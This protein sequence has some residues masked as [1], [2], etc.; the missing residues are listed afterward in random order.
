MDNIAQLL[1]PDNLPLDIGEKGTVE[2]AHQ[3]IPDVY[4][5]L[6]L[7]SHPCV[8][9]DDAYLVLR[10]TSNISASAKNYGDAVPG[11]PELLIFTYRDGIE[12]HYIIDY[13][14]ALYQI[15]HG[16]TEHEDLR[17]IASYGAE[18]FPEYFGDFPVPVLTPWGCATRNK[19]IFNGVF[20][21]ETEL[22]RR[23][24]AVAFPCT[25]DLIQI[26]EPE[27]MKFRTMDLAE[28]FEYEMAYTKERNTGYAFFREENSCVPL[29]DLINKEEQYGTPRCKIDRA[30]L[31]NA[32]HCRCPEYPYLKDAVDENA[33]TEFIVF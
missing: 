12:T 16:E 31:V 6:V 2:Q 9:G 29:Y 23:G 1:A 17:E 5:C 33:G 15:L 18:V 27:A 7:T 30:A 28:P 22:G 21:L 26:T 24:L 32:V 8:V 4:R 19:I 20:W 11:Y 3:V 14:V 13:E 10:D 25:E